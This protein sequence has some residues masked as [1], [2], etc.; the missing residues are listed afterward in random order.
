MKL[1][2]KTLAKICGYYRT[3]NKTFH[4]RFA[5]NEDGGVI[6]LHRPLL[7]DIEVTIFALVKG[8]EELPPGK[9]DELSYL[10]PLLIVLPC[11][12]IKPELLLTLEKLERLWEAHYPF[13]EGDSLNTIFLIYIVADAGRDASTGERRYAYNGFSPE[14]IENIVKQELRKQGGPAELDLLSVSDIKMRTAIKKYLISQGSKI[15]LR[16]VNE[17]I[18]KAKTEFS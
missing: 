7:I 17:S 4:R 18:Q 6:Y 1:S 11:D 5:E 9:L 10:H 13:G 8:I 2:K 14:A 16:Q 12:I 15:T 3:T